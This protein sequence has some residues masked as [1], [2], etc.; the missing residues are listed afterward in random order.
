MKNTHT[1][2]PNGIDSRV[3]AQDISLNDLVRASAIVNGN[4]NITKAIANSC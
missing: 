2:F 1:I 3:Y 4:I